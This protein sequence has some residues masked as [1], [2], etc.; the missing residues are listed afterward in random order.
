[1]SLRPWIRRW[2]L[3]LLGLLLA[4]PSLRAR[5]FA[6]DYVQIARLEG[7]SVFGGSRL[8]LY[9]FVPR[10]PA[11]LADLHHEGVVPWFTAPDLRLA[12][13][14]PLS[15]ALMW[16]DHTLWG[17]SPL[18]YHVHT[19]LWYAALLVLAAVLLRRVLPPALA[20]LALVL[21]CLDESHAM[22]ASWVA[23]RNAS[24]ACVLVLA[25][26]LAH[27]RWRE[28]RWLPGAA[29][30][31][32]AVAL[33]LAASEMALGA[34]MYLIAWELV[35][36]RRGWL[37]ALAPTGALLLLY[38]LVYRL[39]GSGAHGSGGYLDPTGDPAGLLQ[40]LPGRV[41]L[42]LGSLVGGTPIDVLNV[43]PSLRVA[44]MAA[45]AGFGL[46]VALWLPGAMHRLEPEEA[47]T[48]RWL[49]LGALGALLVGAPALLGERVLLAASLGGAVVLAVL[50]RDGWR[51]WAARDR[52]LWAAAGLLALGLP[53]LVLGPILLPAK[54][55]MIT[56]FCSNYRR[57]A[58]EAEIS[59]PVPARVV[60][61]AME[62]LLAIHLPL[63]RALELGLDAARMQQLRAVVEQ[64]P[65][66]T[67]VLPRP[68]RLGYRRTTVL[69]LATTTHRVKQTAPD[70]LELWTPAGTL[71]DGPWVQ[72]IRTP[73]QRLARGSVIQLRDFSVTV[74]EDHQGRP[75][76]AAFRFDRPLEDPSLV[77]LAVVDGRL[78]RFTL[79]AVGQ[80]VALSRGR[81]LAQGP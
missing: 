36:R 46:V 10:D 21:F 8:D 81:V 42:L 22:A 37:R 39:T 57:L 24:V 78:Q 43:E 4:L 50:L 18:P 15:S 27:I 53:N 35:R 19:L 69:S 49:G 71:F 12:F 65:P 80:E 63:I 64:G 13:F 16:L 60:V 28:D 41:L 58:R 5:F 20:T 6:D 3:P 9:N 59:A 29:L 68:D 52:R 72:S 23:A 32:L 79:P 30:A 55:A 26:L 75:T 56:G 67:D 45:G 2:S 51:R 76:R 62:D 70:T 7:W 48:V 77:L 33:G 40:A 54:T 17:R 38:V 31:P 34:L 74:L 1:V 14:R 25:G 44:L 61:L 66:A 47:T 11:Q 73:S